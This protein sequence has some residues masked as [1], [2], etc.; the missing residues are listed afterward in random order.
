VE[1]LLARLA[2]VSRRRWPE[3]GDAT[4]RLIPVAAG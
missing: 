4:P 3:G 1:P 2:R